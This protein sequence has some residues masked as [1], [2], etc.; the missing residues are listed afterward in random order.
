MTPTLISILAGGL[1]AAALPESTA[2]SP[3]DAVRGLV[4]QVAGKTSQVEI[5]EGTFVGLPRPAVGIYF[6]ASKRTLDE[7]TMRLSVEVQAFTVRRMLSRRLYT[8]QLA[9]REFV[10][11]PKHVLRVGETIRGSDLEAVE[12]GLRG[13]AHRFALSLEQLVGRVVKRNLLPGRPVPRRAVTLPAAVKRGAFVSV[14]V[15]AGPMLISMK[16]ESLESGAM[17]EMV[18]VLNP[19]SS[20]VLVGRVVG[21]D[22][23]EVKR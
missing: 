2:S 22:Q 8:F 1:M 5:D 9:S 17:G 4:K 19:S 15:R 18:R 23:I 14:Q 7:T 20:R 10:L 11:V 16:G 3:A 13:D 21:P 12:I 6:K